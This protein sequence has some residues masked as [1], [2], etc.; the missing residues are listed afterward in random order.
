LNQT[1]KVSNYSDES[2]KNLSNAIFIQYY[3]EL[4]DK[5]NG[6]KTV[7][8]EEEEEETE[9]KFDHEFIGCRVKRQYT[10]KN[11]ILKNCGVI[12]GWLPA[13]ENEGLALWHVKHDDYD[14]EDLEEDEAKES[15]QLWLDSDEKIE[16]D[17]EKQKESDELK[18]EEIAK[19]KAQ[20]EED[21]DDDGHNIKNKKKKKF[22]S[23]IFEGKTNTWKT[24]MNK[25]LPPKDRIN[26][27]D[28]GFNAFI[29]KLYKFEE[30]CFDFI[31]EKEKH[32]PSSGHN[33]NSVLD[34]DWSKGRNNIGPARSAWRL[35]LETS[36]TVSEI[37]E[38]LITFEE[39]L[40]TFQIMEDID[41]GGLRFKMMAKEGWLFGLNMTIDGKPDVV[42]T[43]STSSSSST[44]TT[45]PHEYVGKCVRQFYHG[46]KS[47][48]KIVAY[49]PPDESDDESEA[50]WH[51][52]HVDGDEEDLDEAEVSKAIE[53]YD[54][55]IQNEN[56]DNK[57]E[58]DDEEEEDNDDGDGLQDSEEEEEEESSDEDDDEDDEDDEEEDESKRTLWATLGVRERWRS[59]VRKSKTISQLALALLILQEAATKFGIWNEIKS[60][61]VRNLGSSSSSNRRSSN[62]SLLKQL[63]VSSG[64]GGRAAAQAARAKISKSAKEEQSIFNDDHQSNKRQRG[65]RSSS[66]SSSNKRKSTSSSSRSSKNKHHD[67]NEK[68]SN[69]K[70]KTSSKS[71]SRR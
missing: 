18:E 37:S 6:N 44:S 15:I 53:F 64:Y 31:K 61:E 9:W 5:A 26:E 58:K 3:D 12:K 29:D 2:L 30:G 17:L 57:D 27:D 70:R 68:N 52:I 19:Q 13:E 14:S 51:M 4:N 67:K 41:D 10:V 42:S 48:G 25:A 16:Y 34:G 62:G 65:D 40:R 56:E 24:Y 1:I 39:F 36:K 21:D 49:L 8:G 38:V 22:I 23:N 55:N 71:R 60:K 50:L 46:M 7:G 69:K 28:L 63:S 43:S 35:S 66:F 47:D 11:K 54:K 59:V 32:R 45:Q 33:G 20:E